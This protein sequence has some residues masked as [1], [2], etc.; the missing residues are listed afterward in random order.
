MRKTDPLTRY[1]NNHEWARPDGH[2]VTIGISDFGQA[3]AKDIHA[4]FLPQEGR[5]FKKAE[6][7]CSIESSKAVNEV[8][9]PISGKI[10]VVN[11][12]LLDDPALVNKDCY[13]QGWLAKIQAD[14]LEEWNKLMDAET[15]WEEIGVF[16]RKKG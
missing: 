15:Y 13:G 10:V 11:D 3:V 1:T 16:F 2:L 9:M 14:D 6:V 7:F 4:V 8:E 5:F 12:L